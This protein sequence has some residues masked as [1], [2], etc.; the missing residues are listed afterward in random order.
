MRHRSLIPLARLSAVLAV[1]GAA[2]AGPFRGP[3]GGTAH[4]ADPAKKVEPEVVKLAVRP[5]APPRP[6]LKYQLLPPPA[7]QQPGNAAPLYLVACKLAQQYLMDS[8]FDLLAASV[9]LPI[10]Q[11]LRDEAQQM[12]ERYGTALR[13]LELAARRVDCDWSLPVREEGLRLLLP[14]LNDL[15]HLASVLSVQI[16]LHVVDG[17]FDEAVRCLQTGFA[18]AAHVG[19]EA[20]ML[21][22]MVAAGIQDMMLQRVRE[23]M[24]APGAPNLYWA[25]AD[26]PTPLIDRRAVMRWETSLLEF[27]FPQLPKVLRGEVPAEESDELWKQV[28]R[29]IGIAGPRGHE[30]DKRVGGVLYTA[31]LYPQAK[32]HL[33][34]SGVPSHRVEQMPTA[35]VVA[36]YQWAEFRGLADELWKYWNLPY[37]EAGA[38]LAEAERRMLERHG[39]GG[40][41]YNPF[42]LMLPSIHRARRYLERGPREVAALRC[43]EAIRAYAAANEGRLPESLE[44]A[45]EATGM[46]APADPMTGRPF[47]Y[48]LRGEGGEAGGGAVAVVTAVTPPGETQE[49]TRFWTVHYEVTLAQ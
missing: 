1:L 16:R 29:A 47:A 27:S 12:V 42:V 40:P 13:Q 36:A 10:D 45:Q 4:A 48:E 9:N 15:R 38:R 31:K 2:F 35:H 28:M 14:H 5:A 22:A 34:D 3:L 8:H 46:P 41:D 17:R 21:Q 18:L 25:L 19:E 32:Q 24:S 6:A 20:V 26:L 49:V 33:I 39:A 11:L 37:W 43:V 7:E 23:F 44:Q 30:W